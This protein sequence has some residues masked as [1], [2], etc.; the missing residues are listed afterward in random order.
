MQK[1][2]NKAEKCRAE[3]ANVGKRKTMQESERCCRKVQN[4]V[5]ECRKAQDNAGR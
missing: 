5:G 1:I 3:Q 2:Q 4:R